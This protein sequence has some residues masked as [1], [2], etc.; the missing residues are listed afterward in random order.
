MNLDLCT[1][2]GQTRAVLKLQEQQQRSTTMTAS[3]VGGGHGGGHGEGGDSGGINGEEEAVGLVPQGQKGSKGKLTAAEANQR[4]RQHYGDTTTGNTPATSAT[5][6]VETMTRDRRRWASER[7]DNKMTVMAQGTI[8]QE[9]L[10]SMQEL[11]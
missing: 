1:D 10:K 3:A 2:N 9:L 6:T 5:S 7:L 8:A 4:W 11:L